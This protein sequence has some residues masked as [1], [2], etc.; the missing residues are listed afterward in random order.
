MPLSLGGDRRF[1]FLYQ[2]MRPIHEYLVPL[3]E[4]SSDLNRGREGT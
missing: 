2:N 1:R 4:A 3:D